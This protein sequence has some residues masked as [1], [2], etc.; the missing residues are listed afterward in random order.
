MGSVG[1]ILK[2]VAVA[3]VGIWVINHGLDKLGLTQFKA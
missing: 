1:D 3:F 2:I